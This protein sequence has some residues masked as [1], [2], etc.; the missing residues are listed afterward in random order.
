[1]MSKGLNEWESLLIGDE[2]GQ[3]KGVLVR[4]SQIVG[5]M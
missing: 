3:R 2:G 5:L 4:K 1:M